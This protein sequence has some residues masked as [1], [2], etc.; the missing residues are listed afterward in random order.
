MGYTRKET[1]VWARGQGKARKKM[2]Y[3]I[4]DMETM[5]ADIGWW[6]WMV[7]GG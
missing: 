2:I 1:Q 3:Q 7:D 5:M 6:I 4:W